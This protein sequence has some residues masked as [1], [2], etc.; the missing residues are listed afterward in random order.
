MTK[1]KRKFKRRK[2]NEI[3]K[4]TKK[5]LKN[6]EKSLNNLPQ[7]CSGCNTPFE[8]SEADKWTI[9]VG[10]DGA[11]MTCP[12]CREEIYESKNKEAED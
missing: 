5:Q 10:M 2:L 8:S 6:V 7:Q 11:L 9:R 3:K 1:F 4:R 12:K